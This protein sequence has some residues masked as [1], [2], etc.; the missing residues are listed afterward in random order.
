MFNVLNS[1]DNILSS[2]VSLEVISMCL[3]EKQPCSYTFSAQPHNAL[4]F[5]E[6]WNTF[7]L[8]PFHRKCSAAA[9]AGGSFF[10]S[11]PSHSKT[12]PLCLTG[13]VGTFL[14]ELER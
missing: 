13:Q 14:D 3:S 7:F 4:G 6:Y 5:R 12:K 9:L 10:V 8:V 2:V 11:S 1:G